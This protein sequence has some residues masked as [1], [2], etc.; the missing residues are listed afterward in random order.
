MTFDGVGLS[1]VEDLWCGGYHSFAKVRK[2]NQWEYY[3]WGLNKHGQLGLR[4]YEET[5]YPVELKKLAGTN[6]VEVAA[7]TNFSVLLT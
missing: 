3:A 7:G 6:V 4:S 1:H 2:H 5:A